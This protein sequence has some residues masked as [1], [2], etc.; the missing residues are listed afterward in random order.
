MAV[1]RATCNECG[2][3]ELA[4][5]QVQV[6]VCLD[7]QRSSYAFR[8]PSCSHPVARPVENRLV[9]LLASSGSPVSLWHLPAE[10]D[11]PHDGPEITHDDLLDFHELLTRD[12][13]WFVALVSEGR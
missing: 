11:E 12:D 4:P 5:L 2:D 1:I 3:I 7:D 6:R 8:C 10:L 13:S 9:E